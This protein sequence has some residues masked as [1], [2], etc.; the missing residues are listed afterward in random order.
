MLP[1][2][3]QSSLATA[4]R[5]LGRLEAALA[6]PAIRRRHAADARTRSVRAVLRLDGHSVAADDLHLI[7]TAPDAVAPGARAD[8]ALG[9]ALQRWA[10][11]LD[12]GRAP[13]DPTPG[14]APAPPPS[15][16]TGLAADG[17]RAALEGLA[18]LVDGEDTG[19]NPAPAATGPAVDKTP[20]L[21]PWTVPWAM[22]A[23]AGW[24]EIRGLPE[25]GAEAADAIAAGL[26]TVARTLAASPGLDGA[27]RAMVQLHH[28]DDPPLPR[29]RG[30]DD[31]FE[32]PLARHLRRQ[33]QARSGSGFWSTLARLAAPALLRR[34]C[35]L[36]QA[37]LP[38]VASLAASPAPFRAM[39]VAAEEEAVGWLLGQVSRQAEA[40]LQRLAELERR[41]A[42]HRAALRGRR[43]D[44]GVWALLDQLEEEPALT[45][46]QAARRL[47]CSERAAR[48]TLALLAEAG[49]LRPLPA[50]R[51]VE[52]TPRRTVRPLVWLA[53]DIMPV[54]PAVAKPAR[55]RT[56][57]LREPGAAMHWQPIAGAPQDGKRCL[58]W[59][60]RPA[61]AAYVAQAD[62]GGQWREGRRVLQPTH[63]LP[64]APPEQADAKAS[65]R[66]DDSSR[67]EHTGP[68]RPI[69]P[70]P[71]NAT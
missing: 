60:G 27:L 56:T 42:A 71:G 11:A 8:A 47:G 29:R 32:N 65:G 46:R 36:T 37:E 38:L 22:A 53:A 21:F 3:F 34:A 49:I 58:V 41:A 18:L 16:P 67:E 48:T 54:L 52:E 61:W 15:H 30:S 62:G 31:P 24:S 1:A 57:A 23:L 66:K 10:A 35:G 40:E 69:A 44:A 7:G 55:R 13:G 26:A 5:A 2:R 64:L 33:A 39:L 59:A 20:S 43:R 70:R 17:L 25:P 50:W 51:D 12:G 68:G 28:R 6:D 45:V 4:E 9:A 19:A 63:W 14:I